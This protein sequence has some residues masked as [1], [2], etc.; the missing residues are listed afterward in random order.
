[1]NERKPERKASLIAPDLDATVYGDARNQVAQHPRQGQEVS[2]MEVSSMEIR[3]QP[4]HVGIVPNS[5]Q[6]DPSHN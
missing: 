3:S 5:G 4:G 2:S 6:D 1:M